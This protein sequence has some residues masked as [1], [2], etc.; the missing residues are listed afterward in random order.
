L[1]GDLGGKLPPVD[2]ELGEDVG[3]MVLDRL[4]ADAQVLGDLLVAGALRHQRQDL[5][6]P[7]GEE[8]G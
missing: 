6:L 8:S 1:P 2:A 4:E 7:W 5:P 3:E